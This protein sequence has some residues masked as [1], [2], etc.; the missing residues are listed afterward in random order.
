MQERPAGKGNDT[1]RANL[2][3]AHNLI[4]GSAKQSATLGI[5]T[6]KAR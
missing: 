3:V 2:L 5:G 4:C 1:I 6:G